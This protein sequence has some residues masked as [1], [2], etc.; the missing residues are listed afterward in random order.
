MFRFAI[1]D[2]YPI[3]R[4]GLKE[5]ILETF[6]DVTI[7]EFERGY[8]FIR[9]AQ[10]NQYDL[11][12]LD[13]SL[14]DISG[15][16]ALETIKKIRPRVPVLIVSMHPEDVYAVRAIKAGAHGYISK[17]SV[18]AELVEAMRTVLAGKRYVSPALAEKMRLDLETGAEKAPHENLS[19]RELQV[20]VLI[21]EGKTTKQIGD[22]LHLSTD[23]VNTYRTRISKKLNLKGTNQLM[24]Y[25]IASG[26]TEYELSGCTTGTQQGQDI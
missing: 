14:A 12:L 23:T 9:N 15:I 20:L 6:H 25:A 13:I 16:E 24:H 10:S 3:V 8:D 11:A 17:R 4:N 22:D 7:D 18:V 5:I 26:L 1:I 21:G 19:F 2:D